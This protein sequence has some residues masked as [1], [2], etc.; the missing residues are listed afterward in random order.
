MHAGFVS[1]RT[2][3]RP[4]HG[5][6]AVR[7]SSAILAGVTFSNRL[8]PTAKGP[9][10]RIGYACSNL[11]LRP[12]AA[13]TFKLSSY[14]DARL[15]ETVEENL[16]ALESYLAWNAAHDIFFFRISSDTIP[17]ASH[18]VMTVDWQWHFAGRLAAIGAFVTAHHMRI[19]VH[20]GQYT[21]LNS[22][23]PDVIERSIAELVYHADLLDRMGLDHTHKIQIHVGGVYGNKA[24][25]STRFIETYARLPEPVRQRLVIEND[26]RQYNLA[27]A[28]R[29]HEAT[30]IPVLLDVLHHRLFN[31]GESLA[32]ALDLALPTWSG[33]GPPMIDYSSQHPDRQR[34]AHALS[35]DLDDFLP[36]V[37]AIGDRTA[38]IMLEIKDKEASALRAM[39]A[40]TGRDRVSRAVAS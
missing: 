20:P 11:S 19:G 27:D 14:S 25:A 28:I 40:L 35:I 6:G 24:S 29:I 9:M 10:I 37:A 33:H 36:V 23:R 30:G 31:E 18:P 3:R 34:G 15:I 5:I 4:E 17:F 21:L 38:D 1:D 32:V 8:E 12:T 26:E 16:T 13:R 39:A 2:G 7:T 22:D